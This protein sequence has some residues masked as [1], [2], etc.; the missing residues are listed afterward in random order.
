MEHVWALYT[1][2]ELSSYFRRALFW[3]T[4]TQWRTKLP[5]L[6]GCSIASV[7][8]CLRGESKHTEL[9]KVV[10]ALWGYN[11]EGGRYA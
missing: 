6:T 7:C 3:V 5:V 8:A 10:N 2:H 9:E 1:S 4:G 11:I